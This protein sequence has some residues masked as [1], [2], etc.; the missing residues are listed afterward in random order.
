M[1]SVH[2]VQL[3]RLR[4][5]H[6]RCCVNANGRMLNDIILLLLLRFLLHVH[7]CCLCACH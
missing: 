5:G 2:G 3:V 1:M 6:V 7:A 4:V